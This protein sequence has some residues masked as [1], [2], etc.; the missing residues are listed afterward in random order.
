MI[1]LRNQETA[2]RTEGET[3][4]STGARSSRLNSGENVILDNLV[5]DFIAVN[6]LP[7][8]ISESA[9]FRKLIAKISKTHVLPHQ[10]K[11]TNVTLA[12]RAA[13]MRST[14]IAKLNSSPNHSL[15]LECDSVSEET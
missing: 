6:S 1:D 12:K 15:T 5:T 7:I 2:R 14:G 4:P 10:T 3:T 9:G 11:F 13:H 8:N